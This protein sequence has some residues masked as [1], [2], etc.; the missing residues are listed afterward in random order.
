VFKKREGLLLEGRGPADQRDKEKL[1][2][3]IRG[4]RL[5]KAG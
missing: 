1:E 4:G 3:R 5:W 2:K